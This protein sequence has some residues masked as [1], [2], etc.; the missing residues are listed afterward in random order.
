MQ[1]VVIGAGYLGVSFLAHYRL[2]REGDAS[3][4][5]SGTEARLFGA[6]LLAGAAALVGENLWLGSPVAPLDS[7]LQWTSALTTTGFA[8]TE[9][10]VWA[11]APLLWL[12]LAMLMGL[13]WAGRLE[14]FPVLL[15]A[16]YALGR[17]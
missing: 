17:R 5:V 3:A 6:L 4:L 7:A 2:L 14:I 9:L 10:A 12:V 11:P 1:L 16:A 8:S 15:L 13:M